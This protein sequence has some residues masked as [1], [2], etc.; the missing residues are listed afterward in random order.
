M[1]IY[2][3]DIAREIGIKDSLELIDEKPFDYFA[4]ATT[5]VHGRKCI[6]V[7]N[8]KYLDNID[9]SVSMVVTSAE[10][11]GNLDEHSFGLCITENVR[12]TF[13]ELMSRQEY[14]YKS[15][16]KRTIIGG[17]C[18][19]SNKAII[20][21]SNVVIGNNVKIG[22]F[23]VIHPNVI[24]GDN[25]IIQTAARIGEQDFNVYSYNGISKQVYHGGKV[26]IGPNVLISS[27][28]L[29]G[30][31]LYSYDTTE[32]GCNCFIGANTCIGHNSKIKNDCEICGNSMLGGYCSIGSNSKL[33]MNVT[34]ANATN[35]GNNATV[36]M[37]SVVIREV[38]DSITVFGN[39]AREVIAPK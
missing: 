7:A 13:F 17:N 35:I 18:E 4:R 11:A 24:I 2:I 30:Q 20:A 19:I 1:D 8:K 22:D 25:V 21:D 9:D 14:R 3:S 29:I 5:E 26:V 12:G 27:G 33:F 36:N 34:V 31:A 15:E 37:G 16:C 39:P 28:V 10:I 38:K 6:F 23:V 32:I